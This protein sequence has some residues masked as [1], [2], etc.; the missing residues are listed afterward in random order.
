MILENRFGALCVVPGIG[1]RHLRR[2]KESRFH[3]TR[4]SRDVSED[5]GDAGQDLGPAAFGLSRYVWRSFDGL[6]IAVCCRMRNKP[7]RFWSA[8]TE[9]RYAEAVVMITQDRD[10]LSGAR[11]LAAIR[12]L[13]P[14]ETAVTR[15]T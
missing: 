9:N 2:L 10:K 1:R 12:W 6:G 7:A 15:P 3:K 14:G 8:T 5:E 4:A 13:P 11:C